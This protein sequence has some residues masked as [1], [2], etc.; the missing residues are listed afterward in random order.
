MRIYEFGLEDDNTALIEER[1]ADD[2][3]GI[4]AAEVYRY[5]AP[6]SDRALSE[7]ANQL[8]DDVFLVAE[9]DCAVAGVL[10]YRTNSHRTVAHIDALATRRELQRRHGVGTTLLAEMEESLIDQGIRMITLEAKEDTGS[11]GFYAKRGFI[12]AGVGNVY[13]RAL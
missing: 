9:Q 7:T 5:Q 10:A 3:L 6:H 2:A 12:W 13:G 1:F 8:C 11:A 4:V